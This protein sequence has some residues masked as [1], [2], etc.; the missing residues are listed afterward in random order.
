MAA[1]ARVP[2]SR[3]R[4]GE[5]SRGFGLSLLIHVALLAAAAAYT[6]QTLSGVGASVTALEQPAERSDLFVDEID[7]SLGSFAAAEP[8]SADAAPPDVVF[9]EVVTQAS[10]VPTLA[11][12]VRPLDGSAGD[13]QDGDAEAR[14]ATG[15]ASAGLKSLPFSRPADGGTVTAGSFT[16]YT[17]PPTPFAGQPYLIVIEIKVPDH[18]S[19][20]PRADLSGQVVG[21]DQYRQPLPGR[22]PSVLPRKE[23]TAQLAVAVPGARVDVEDTITIASRILK[24]RQT[25]TLKFQARPPAGVAGGGPPQ[26]TVKIGLPGFGMVEVPVPPGVELPRLPPPPRISGPPVRGPAPPTFNIGGRNGGGADP[27]Y[28]K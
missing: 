19:R 13:G 21:T 22:G 8:P 25:L 5:W 12:F 24:E 4:L 11:A 3:E 7:T 9:E 27:R 6:F 2:V 17:F 28:R 10:V 20:Y 16:A 15:F 14:D 18:I 1:S 23:R 26:R